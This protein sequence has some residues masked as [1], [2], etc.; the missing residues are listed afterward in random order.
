VSQ[1]SVEVGGFVGC[2]FAAAEP[3]G[4]ISPGLINATNFGDCDSL[5]ESS[6]AVKTET[7]TFEPDRVHFALVFGNFR[8]V[9]D[10]FSAPRLR[11]KW[12]W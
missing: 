7:Q 1:P 4:R 8:R 5:S 12:A 10:D 9:F 11:I 6:N 3:Q 2:G